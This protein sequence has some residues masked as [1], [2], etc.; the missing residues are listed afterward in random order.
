MSGCRSRATSLGVVPECIFCKIVAGEV[1]STEVVSSE[2]SYAFRDIA[3]VM[4]THVLV[5]PRRH[6]DSA[7]ALTGADG[8]LLADM[9]LVAQQVA[10]SE[11][12]AT[13][14]YRLVFNVGRDAQCSVD[15]LHLHVLGGRAMDWPPG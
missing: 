13:D 8:D 1:P 15:H 10:R 6:I 7:D 3:P 14:G 4:P 2:L 9:V 12:V 11:G 5:V